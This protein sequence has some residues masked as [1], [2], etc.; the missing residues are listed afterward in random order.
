MASET[1]V[2]VVNWNGGA[3]LERL[4][5]S[6]Q[7]ASPALVVVVDNASSDRS[8]EILSLF[9]SVHVIRN[10]QNVGFG[11][12]ANQG[13]AF[14]KTPYVLLLNVDIEIQAGALELLEKFLEENPDAAIVAPQLLHTNG[15]LQASCR[16]FPTVWKLFLYLSYLDRL[17]PSDYRLKP[18]MHQITREVEQ[19]MGAAIL[20]RKSALEQTGAFDEEFFLYMEDVELCERLIQAGWK[21]FYFPKAKMIH[22]AGGSSNQDWERS[23]TNFFQSVILYFRKKYGRFRLFLSRISLS[24]ALILRAVLTLLGGNLKKAG[25]YLRM[26]LKL[27]WSGLKRWLQVFLLRLQFFPIALPRNLQFDK[28]PTPKAILRMNRGDSDNRLVRIPRS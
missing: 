4:L 5:A 21:I 23:Q 28:H 27:L 3:Y 16:K 18:G 10:L 13:I 24:I 9:P 17:V 6:V 20:I 26:S 8:L 22:H 2:V 14:A 25:F 15:E 12:A 1:T 19:P 11:S 7:G